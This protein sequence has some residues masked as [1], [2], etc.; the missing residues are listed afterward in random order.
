MSMP[1]RASSKSHRSLFKVLLRALGIED[2]YDEEL[3]LPSTRRYV[4]GLFS[5]CRDAPYLKG[6]GVLG[7]GTESFT[8]REYSRIANGLAQHEFLEE[9][10]LVFFSTHVGVD[11]I[12]SQELLH[13]VAR[14]VTSAEAREQV[15]QGARLAIEMELGFWDGLQSEIVA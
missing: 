4:E 15:R 3:I 7:P 9:A 8:A 12:H 1:I 14:S 5:V 13:C 2:S 6:L 11:D 10:D